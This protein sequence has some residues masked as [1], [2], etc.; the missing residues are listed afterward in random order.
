MKI[1]IHMIVKDCADNLKRAL[2]SADGL[3]NELAIV[4]TG[5][6]DGKTIEVAK[7]FTKK[8]YHWQNRW[9]MPFLDDFA[10]AR[11]LAL[12]KLPKGCAWHMWLDSDDVISDA[13]IFRKHLKHFRKLPYNVFGCPYDVQ[14]KKTPIKIRGWRPNKVTWIHR[15]HEQ[16]HVINPKDMDTGAFVPV[17]IKH[18]KTTKHGW[19]ESMVRN[20]YVLEDCL[21]DE[22][23]NAYYQKML[24]MEW[25]IYGFHEK[26]KKLAE[27]YGVNY[28]DI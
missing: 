25:K 11:N 2:E 18:M 16:M 13:K 14:F 27:K 26:G 24:I 3:Y 7:Q 9:N 4:D 28:D 19:K 17:T 15:I 5:S 20:L 23:D 6:I 22:P 21:K 8:V 1:G 10:G 12:S